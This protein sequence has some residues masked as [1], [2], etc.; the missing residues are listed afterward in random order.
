MAGARGASEDFTFSQVPLGPA[1][2]DREAT[3]PDRRRGESI[4]MFICNDLTSQIGRTFR[5]TRSLLRHGIMRAFPSS[6]T[7]CAERR[8]LEWKAKESQS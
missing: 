7:D 5:L 3:L 2:A 4:K 6:I 8:V 1:Q